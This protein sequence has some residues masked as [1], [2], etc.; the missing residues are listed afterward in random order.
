L[1]DVAA[2]T[3][4]QKQPNSQQQQQQTSLQIQLQLMHPRTVQQQ[5]LA[6]HRACL[7]ALQALGALAT[8]V[9]ASAAWGVQG[10]EAG[11]EA[12]LLRPKVGTVQLIQ[13][14]TL[15]KI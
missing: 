10:L 12:L 14:S 6:A 7:A 1:F 9:E 5:E 2:A 13:L 11:S 8:A 4:K 3:R 15:V